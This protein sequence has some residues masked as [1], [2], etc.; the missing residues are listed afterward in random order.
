MDQY[1]AQCGVD[2]QAF[3][4]KEQPFLKKLLQS[5]LFQIVLLVLTAILIGQY[6]IRN[7]RTPL[8]SNKIT[9]TNGASRVAAPPPISNSPN[10]A[11]IING[12]STG[13]LSQDLS[14]AKKSDLADLK[15]QEIAVPK[16]ESALIAAGTN[17]VASANAPS[18]NENVSTTFKI[19]YA[20]IK[21]EVLAQLINESESQGLFQNLQDYSAGI[22]SDFRSHSN[23]NMT[24]L[25]SDQ[26]RIQL[27]QRAASFASASGD[28]SASLNT[29][30]E[31]RGNDNGTVRGRIAIERLLSQNSGR[32]PA[33]FDLPRGAAFLMVGVLKPMQMSEKVI[34]TPP[35][36]VYKSHDF[37]T[38]K[39][40]FVIIIEPDYK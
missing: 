22:I 25:H 28:R 11:T 8:W 26:K 21:R 40:E 23:L 17:R 30:I 37:M 2:M 19:T 32:F 33:E 35:F 1:C 4:P 27:G 10:S 29:V 7:D 3:K 14:P 6:I 31:L 13:S 5:G 16:S 15:N 38:Q 36:Q 9:R 24:V 20:E 12:N 34:N 39:T 18:A